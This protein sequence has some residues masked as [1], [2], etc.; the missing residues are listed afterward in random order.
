MPSG[1]PW[2]LHI[3]LKLRRVSALVLAAAVTATMQVAFAPLSHAGTA[4]AKV[5]STTV[6]TYTPDIN[7]GVVYA[8]NQVGSRIIVG[9]DFTNESPHGSSTVI[10][11]SYVFA[12]DAS[13]G[14]IDPGFKPTLDGHVEGV[15][16]GPTADTV[17]LTG[18]FNTVNGVKSKT[19]TL[20]NTAN[21]QIVTGFKPPVFNGA[22]FAVKRAG[23]QVY[24]GGTFSTVAGVAHN[25]L[26]ALDASTGQLNTNVNIQLTGHHNYNG[27]SGAN[28]AVGPRAMS[29][30]PNGTSLVVIG[31]FK[32]ANG[33]VH[34]QIDWNTLQ[35][36]AACF[37]GSFDTYMRG[38]DWAPDGS[39]F[40][41][42]ATGGSGTNTD[43]TRSLCDTAARFDAA[44]S[45]SNVKATWADY[46]G[47]D[48]ILSVAIT[49][50]AVYI[51][52]HE[53][54]LNNTNGKDY[55]GTGAVPRPGMA[56]LDPA[57]GLPL[58]WNP[59]RNPR[60]A[61]AYAMFASA[62]GLYVGSDTDYFGNFQ[63]KHKK[64]G[65]F[66]L[67]GGT[68]PASTAVATLPANVYETGP[69][70]TPP[71]TYSSSLAYRAY[72]STAIGP[73][74]T[75]SG[76]GI[77]WSLTRGAF[78][79]GDTIYYGL[80]TGTFY[81][82]SFDGTTVGTPVAGDPYDDP[83]WSNVQNGSGGTYQGT[84]SAYYGQLKNVTGAFFNGGRM[85]YSLVGDATLHYR[86]FTPD[87][88]IL[89]AEQ[90]NATGGSF[91]NVSGE[92]VSGTSLYYA[93]KSDGTL[94]RTTFTNGVIS[95]TDTAV[96]GPAI[97]GN[98]WRARSLFAYGNAGFTNQAPTASFTKSCTNLSC[99]FD[100]SGSSDP[101]GSV[102]SY[103][104][105]FGDGSTGTGVSPS[106]GYATAGTYTVTLTVTDDRGTQSAPRT[107]TVTVSGATGGGAISFVGKASSYAAST[108]SATVATPAS[109]STG[110][111]ELL[112]VSTNVAVTPTAPAG[113]TLVKTQSS[114][115]LIATV[116]SHVAAAGDAGSTVTV[117]LS[118]TT[119]VALQL[120]DYGDVDTAAITAVGASD[121]STA[122]HVAPAT[123]VSQS[124]SYVVSFWSDKSSTTT[125][126]SLPA[127]VTQRDVIIGTGGG[128][129]TAAVA[130][131][132]AGTGAYPTRTATVNAASGK[133]AM[134]SL[135]LSPA[136]P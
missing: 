1:M 84:I 81:K 135:V 101:D 116:F 98:D 51:G 76:T 123:T 77:D 67:A 19:V 129:V 136:G 52:G 16:P 28:G 110:D 87:S 124:G 34:D 121:A 95:G 32:M 106:H 73:R 103:A 64:I 90:F 39:Y 132:A 44:T 111:T 11:Q 105:N 33:V 112:F 63:Y 26:V 68:S 89:G 119:G 79:V 130:D 3:M 46:A 45:G 75:V 85:Y 4:Q 56:A 133:G 38:V 102:V 36:T 41:V 14:A 15:E 47:Q 94:H 55:A 7:D 120:L 42:A 71:S 17:Y 22:G 18:F 29:I 86:Y 37:S 91:S 31:N 74:T 92:F 30:S 13:T 80:A 66:P 10:N 54:W 96:S 83:T 65:Y 25:G 93:N 118:A 6:A 5:V 117:G 12:F 70:T 114:S 27:S 78:M 113:W 134:L 126:W 57:N 49:G 20:L 128:R 21:G 69:L 59:G 104:W 58:A 108:T 109:V 100:G 60:G 40:V 72:S 48:T 125:G 8:I 23:N 35:Y 61:G 97:D 127:A 88:G 50:T 99:Q 9:G 62:T 107:S 131:S 53:R 82:A 24:V 2:G 122:T 43:G 115:P